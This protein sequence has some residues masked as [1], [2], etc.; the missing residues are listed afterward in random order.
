MTLWNSEPKMAGEI[1]DQ[2]NRVQATRLLRMSRLKSANPSVSANRSPLTCGRADRL[3][4]RFVWRSLRRFIEHVEKPGQVRTE[5]G[6]VG[7]GAI[8]N[9]QPE[10]LALENAGVLGKQAE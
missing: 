8:L 9:V 10:C 4:S 3:S 7:F 2:S 5:V 1:C 6:A